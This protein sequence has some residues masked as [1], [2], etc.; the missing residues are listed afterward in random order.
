[1][2]G[3]ARIPCR[4]RSELQLPIGEHARYHRTSLKQV[5]WLASQSHSRNRARSTCGLSP[6]HDGADSPRGRVAEHKGHST[7]TPCLRPDPCWSNPLPALRPSCP[8]RTSWSGWRP[9]P[10][11]ATL[12]RGLPAARAPAS[13][14]QAGIC[15]MCVGCAAAMVNHHDR[16]GAQCAGKA[17]RQEVL[18]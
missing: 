14:L 7:S 5:R 16:H 4:R 12:R 11:A 10:I 6:L 2:H 1:M 13:G 8:S 9:A 17:N 18:L 3:A 15:A